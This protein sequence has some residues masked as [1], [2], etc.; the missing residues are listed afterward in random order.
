MWYKG[1]INIYDGGGYV[2]DLGYNEELVLD[3]ISEF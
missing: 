2:V 3:V 1:V